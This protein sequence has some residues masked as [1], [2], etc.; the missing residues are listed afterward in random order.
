MYRS[1]LVVGVLVVLTGCGEEPAG[2]PVS[3]PTAKDPV[4]TESIARAIETRVED[5]PPLR[6]VVSCPTDIEWR[7]GTSFKCLVKGPGRRLKAT[8]TL[9]EATAD[10]GNRS[11]GSGRTS[12]GEYSW[13]L[14]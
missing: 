12:Q 2:P 8:V 10:S 3:A 13:S 4:N 1:A 9:G 6:W 11:S 7:A 14:N 5:G